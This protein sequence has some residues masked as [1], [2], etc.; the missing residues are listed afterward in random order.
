MN[1]AELVDFDKME[2]VCPRCGGVILWPPR[3]T[4]TMAR[5]D[6]KIASFFV[7]PLHF[8]A[9][10]AALLTL[11]NM[12]K[13]FQLEGRTRNGTGNHFRP[14]GHSLFKTRLAKA[15]QWLIMTHPGNA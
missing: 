1:Y 10:A 2:M 5:I 11:E 4:L 8:K 14:L 13:D 7:Q 3:G 15:R 12:T 6:N 9:F